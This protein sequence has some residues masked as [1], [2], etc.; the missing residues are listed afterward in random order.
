MKICGYQTH[1]VADVH[2][3]LDDEELQKLAESIREDGQVNDIWLVA[4]DGK[5][6]V[7]DGRNRLLATKIAK[8]EPRT[9]FYKGPT[10]LASLLA[11]SRSL[12]E[13]RRHDTLEQRAL[14]AARAEPL[15]AQAAKERQRE[16]GRRKGKAN[17]PE[18][19]Q[20]RDEAAAAYG[21]S[22]RTVQHGKTVIERADPSV[23]RLVERGAMKVSAGAELAECP[24]AEQREIAARL[25]KGGDIRSGHV[26]ALVR[27]NRRRETVA[28]INAEKV[29]P[30][31]IGPFRVLS[32]DFPWPYSNSDGHM[33]SRGHTDY[34]S[35]PIDE[36]IAFRHRVLPALHEDCIWWCWT[37]NL[38]VKDTPRIVDAW[39]FEWI[40]M[41]TWT[42]NKTGMGIN[43]PRG[44]TEHVVLAMRGKPAHTLNEV[45]TWLG[46]R[47]IDV[48]EHSRKPA[49]FYEMV[50][51]H[52]AGA[53]LE[54]FAR[55][56]REGW[57][58]W[59]AEAEKFAAERGAA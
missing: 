40:S 5:A 14:A 16:A 46:D 27:Q 29:P 50:E 53:K 18:A 10:D 52:C 31:P 8:V 55:E 36:I 59:G 35:M 7:L 57:Q 19:R 6:F 58:T 45:T 26:R 3:L 49:E 20:A 44:R 43:A 25:E 2:R 47:A 56:P 28:R 17:L 21:V 23:V 39:G 13:A 51:K 54:L 37:T 41:S 22:P 42:K 38:F 11:F 33:G 15:Y 4:I 48:R 32:T 12:N 24:V 1:P 34:S 9:R 30:L